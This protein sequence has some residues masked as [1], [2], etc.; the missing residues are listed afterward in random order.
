M[1]IYDLLI[2]QNSI[3]KV[4]NVGS[5]EPEV[6][7]KD[8]AKLLM[9]IVGK[10]LKILKMENTQGSPSRRVPDVSL[11]KSI[12]GY[13]ASTNLKEGIKK[14]FDWYREYSFEK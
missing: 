13:E 8:L 7:V 11:C 9:K 10:D 2:N 12:I 5:D 4:I 14:T 3:G 1:I 6:K